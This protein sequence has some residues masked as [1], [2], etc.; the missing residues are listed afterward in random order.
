MCGIIVIKRKDG[1]PAAKAV[2]KRYH[3]QKTR[4]QQGFGYI[5]IHNNEVV[6]YERAATEAEITA[7]L[8][9][10]KAEEVFFHHRMPTSTPNIEEQA[11]PLIIEKA[12]VLDHSYGIL[13]N[14]VISNTIEMKKKHD[15][16]GIAYETEMQA[17]YLTKAGKTVPLTTTKWNDSESIAVETALMMEGKQE[18]IETTGAAVIVGIKTIGRK[19]VDRFFF[20][21]ELNPLFFKEDNTMVSLTSAPNGISVSS[22]H[23]MQMD[24]KGAVQ[25]HP[26]NI[27]IPTAYRSTYKANSYSGHGG[28]Y[29]YD[30]G[31]RSFEQKQLPVLSAT[32]T[33]MGFVKPLLEN[34]ARPVSSFLRDRYDCVVLYDEDTLWSEY[35]RTLAAIDKLKIEIEELD[36]AAEYGY[37]ADLSNERAK[38]EGT[39]DYLKEYINALESAMR[40]KATLAMQ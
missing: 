12:G 8:R 18:T 9:K 31:A 24:S 38:K 30:S 4:G 35:D 16:M 22:I 17:A 34:N 36:A 23:L 10:E 26:R 40:D 15:E 19:V 29:D 33:N 7:K 27:I 28:T 3:Q 20:R 32:P 14:G 1:R 39:L 37:H 2:L 25:K 11:H 21:N 13:H 5:A 6:A